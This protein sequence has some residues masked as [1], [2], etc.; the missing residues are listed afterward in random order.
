MTS[1]CDKPSLRTT[2]KARLAAL[3]PG[4]LARQSEQVCR[5]VIASASFRSARR[6]MLYFPMT[7]PMKGSTK[8]PSPTARPTTPEVDISLI[9]AASFREHRQVYVPRVDWDKKTM[10]AVLIRN[11][12]DWDRPRTPGPHGIMQPPEF[13]RSISPDR[14]DLIIIPGLGF[15]RG[16][17]FK[18]A[19]SLE[20]DGSTATLYVQAPP[21]F[22][23]AGLE[24]ATQP[25]DAPALSV[26]QDFTSSRRGF[27]RIG[28]GGGFY[29]RFL[30]SAAQRAFRLGVAFECQMVDQIPEESWDARMDAI[31][32]PSRYWMLQDA[33]K[34]SGTG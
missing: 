4:D 9:A 27:A 7:G 33:R 31:A 23:G 14:L 6:V 3:S 13:A 25:R 5:H 8:G 15:A 28:R 24:H 17:M 34:A 18:A 32:T 19:L 10:Q 22:K 2:L 16:G 26:E 1:S 29:D 20:H 21:P 11:Q 30:S 12:A